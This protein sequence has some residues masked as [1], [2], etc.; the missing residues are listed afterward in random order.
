MMANGLLMQDRWAA[1]GTPG[2]IHGGLLGRP[3]VLKEGDCI[4]TGG[5]FGKARF[6]KASPPTSPYAS[7]ATTP[8]LSNE[9]DVIVPPGMKL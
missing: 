4:T 7:P 1:K 3:R 9:V 5:L 6:V 8:A 2:V